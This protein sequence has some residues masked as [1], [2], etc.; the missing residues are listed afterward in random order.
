M[1][2]RV[3]VSASLSA[4]AAWLAARP[5]LRWALL[6]AYYLAVIAALAALYGPGR[7]TPPPFVYQGF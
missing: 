7:F 1:F 5:G 6:T 4:A 2:G 3:S